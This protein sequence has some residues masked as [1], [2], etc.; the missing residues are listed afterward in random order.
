MMYNN[1]NNKVSI[2]GRI[3]NIVQYSHE[4]FGEKFYE[5]TLAVERNSGTKDL[6]TI[7]ASQHLL[8]EYQY[9]IDNIDRGNR[10]TVKG[11]FRS[12]NKMDGDKSKLMLTVFAQDILPYDETITPN[13][14][15]LTGY[16]CKPTVYRETPLGREVCDIILAVNRQYNK[17]DYIPCIV[18]GRN[19][20]FAGNLQVGQQIK[21]TG[22]LQSRNYEK[23]LDDETT[24]TKTAYEVSVS[25][26]EVVE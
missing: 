15:E 6:L 20:R 17:S 13:E 7:T 8:N 26:I 4:V 25:R 12:Y 18:W 23:K 24:V 1:T 10:I 5:F 21:I 22:R 14:V 16:I 19:A 2:S 3:A 11:Q 9:Y